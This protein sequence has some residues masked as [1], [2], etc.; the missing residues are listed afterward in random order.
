[1]N[2]NRQARRSRLLFVVL[3]SGSLLLLG[4]VGISFFVKE[5]STPVNR[6]VLA[7]KTQ[8][9]DVSA[10]VAG[11]KLAW[12]ATGEAAV[13]SVEGGIL[14]ISSDTEALRP[15][16]SMAKVIAALA[17]MEKQP[18][19]SGEEGQTYTT[20]AEDVANMSEYFEE[21]GSVK[22]LLIGMKLTQYQAMQRMLI[23][24]DNNMADMLVERVFGSKQAYVSYAQDMLKRMGL[25]KTIVADASGFSPQTVSTPSELV[26]IGIAALKNPVIAEIVAQQQADLPAVGIV[27]NTNELLGIDGVIGIKTGTTEEAGSCLLF[28]ARVSTKDGKPVTLVGVIMGDTSHTNL[29]NDSRKLLAS[30]RQDFGFSLGESQPADISESRPAGLPANAAQRQ[31]QEGIIVAP[32]IMHRDRAARR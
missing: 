32:P 30:V 6:A 13:G 28:A 25:S 12:P 21:G 7:K 5:A 14:A 19:A 3:F 8:A 11:K 22:P 23:A 27:Q 1:M 26:A 18:F 17:I 20:T 2:R 16:A 29:Y 10:L 4:G 15:T 24:S 31:M 9:T